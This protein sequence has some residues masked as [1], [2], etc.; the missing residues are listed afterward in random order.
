[1]SALPISMP[2]RRGGRAHTP[3][4]LQ[5][6]A[7]EC[8]AAALGIILG[9]YGRY[10]ALEELRVSCGVSRD[11]S[12][13]SNVLR[14]ARS[15]GLV[16]QGYKHEVETLRKARLPAIV[17]WNFSHFLVVEGFGK[18][19]VFLND[20]AK[21]PWV[22]TD[23]EFDRGFTG[24]V[25]T[26][27]PGPDFH[28]GG[29]PPRA[30]PVLARWLEGSR[31][32][33]V[34]VILASLALVVLQ[35]VVPAFTRAY[36][37]KVVGKGLT[38]FVPILIA[39]MAAVV[40]GVAAFTWLQ[41]R[42]L[43]RLETKLSLTGSSSFFWRVLR[44][45]MAFFTQRSAGDLSQRVLLNDRVATLLS[46]TLATN[47][48]GIGLL[49]LFVLLMLR[50]DVLLTVVAVVIAA[51]NLVALRYVSRKRTDQNKKLLQEQ[52]QMM[53]TVMNGL[54]SIETLK[55]AGTESDFFARWGGYQ[56]RVTN[57]QQ[58]LGVSTRVLGEVPLLLA[59]LNTTAILILGSWQVMAGR[60]SIG[61]LV[62][63]QV[64]AAAF[65]AP[66]AGLIS[67]GSEFQE[68]QGGLTRLDDVQHYPVDPSLETPTAVPDGPAH[69]VG[70]VELRN[71]TF[72]YSPLAD[73]LIEDFN[74]TVEPGHRVALVG[75]SGSGKSTIASLVT[76]L[77]QPWSG[78]VLFDGRP[79]EEI[80]RGLLTS[81]LAVANQDIALFEGTVRDNITMWDHSV[82]LAEV[83]R[84]AK[85]AHIHDDVSARPGGYGSQLEE[86]GR[87]LS[88]GQRQR[89]EIARA[90]AGNPS[91]LVLDEA[92]SALDPVTEQQ[93]D[94]AIRRRG[95]TCLIIAHRLSTIRD[96]DEII[97]LQRGK[98]AERGTHEQLLQRGGLYSQLMQVSEGAEQQS[99]L[100][101]V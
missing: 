56:A 13:A 67:L 99:A 32:G 75:I 94:D 69:L 57:A 26:F 59:S 7:V 70:R 11:G 38:S 79:R 36:I 78:Q 10:V 5:M 74:L 97:V 40:I 16:A 63:F 73:P 48:L 95:C 30:L 90:L 80:P 76:G 96:A 39:G 1:M 21:G 46:G 17:F 29:S 43:L 85:D 65:L 68:V 60:L 15:Y 18:G 25:L 14:A 3:T 8:G 51:V 72:G 71:I 81:S 64:L 9:Y 93:V 62:G 2:A 4:V 86:G 58:D 100:E 34:Y 33:L 50:Y 41:Q 27:E 42:F 82:P 84:A 28:R 88:G 49:V 61:T 12:K 66:V 20:P 35:L 54:Q 91:V 101:L 92:T 98:V 24:V 45:P 6:E 31:T 23:E 19:K 87:N 83:I 52:G 77:Y 53:G 37:D 44:M 89:L 47:L 55:A 22:A